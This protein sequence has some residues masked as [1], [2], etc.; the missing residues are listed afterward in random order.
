M[1]LYESLVIKSQYY[2]SNRSI[3]ILFAYMLYTLPLELGIGFWILLQSNI[4][5][6]PAGMSYQ[7]KWY[8][9]THFITSA[10]ISGL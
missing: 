6:G 10:L 8:L 1:Q 5:L 9:L 2:R 7:M 4:I 3:G